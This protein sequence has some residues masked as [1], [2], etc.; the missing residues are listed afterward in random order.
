M[1]WAEFQIRGFAYRRMQEKEET[2]TR[3]IAWNALVGSH[4]DPKKLPKTIDKF[5]SIGNKNSST[6]DKMKEAMEK[7]R[8]EYFK[9]KK[10]LNG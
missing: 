5:W 6:T 4:S 3:V 8:G 9:K 2:L 1:T 10:E 7:A